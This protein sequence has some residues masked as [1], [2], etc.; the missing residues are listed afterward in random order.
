ML[1]DYDPSQMKLISRGLDVSD[2]DSVTHRARLSLFLG[3]FRLVWRLALIDEIRSFGGP[4]IA[5]GRT[6]RSDC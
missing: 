4:A 5:S 1:R 3:R 2:A 6:A